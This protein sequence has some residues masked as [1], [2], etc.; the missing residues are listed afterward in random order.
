MHLLLKIVAKTLTQKPAV[1]LLL[2][3]SLPSALSSQTRI[4]TATIDTAKTGA[5]IS[6]NIYGQF[7]EHGGDIVNTG[8]WSEMLVDR[9][10]FYP[11]ATSAPTPPP[12][13]GNAAGNP[14]FRRTPTR[15]WAPIGG[16]N[17][18][19]MDT[20][21]G[22]SRSTYGTTLCLTSTHTIAP[23]PTAP[24]AVLSAT[25]WAAMVRRALA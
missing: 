14:R 22:I 11:V 18:V 1:C 7:L 8:V 16:D 20:R 24:A 17:V 25:P 21:E 3:L 4:V 13:M 5:P 9:K 19:T 15:W 10:F 23:S 2:L 12:V 6:K